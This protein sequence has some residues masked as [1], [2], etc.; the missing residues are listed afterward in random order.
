MGIVL[1][2]FLP[3]FTV[4]ASTLEKRKPSVAQDNEDVVDLS[5]R[6]GNEQEIAPLGKTAPRA[7]PI[8][9]YSRTGV[10]GL[11]SIPKWATC[12]LITLNDHH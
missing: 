5:R 7:F 11:D 2:A 12:N 10:G 8:W 9:R 6:F 1:Q 3:A 4:A